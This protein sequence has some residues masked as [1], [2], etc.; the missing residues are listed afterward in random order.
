ME[1]FI[2]F[3]TGAIH[4]HCSEIDV[5]KTAHSTDYKLI[6]DWIKGIDK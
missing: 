2:I 1:G 6:T 4:S 5:C 3:G